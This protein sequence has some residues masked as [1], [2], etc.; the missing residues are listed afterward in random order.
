M[1]RSAAAQ[2]S[3]FRPQRIAR[4]LVL[5]QS[6]S[7]SRRPQAA[8]NASAL[9]TASKT[10]HSGSSKSS[11]HCGD[12]LTAST[13]ERASNK[14]R[15]RTQAEHK[16]QIAATAALQGKQFSCRPLLMIC[17]KKLRQHNQLV[18]QLPPLV[19]QR[20]LMRSNCSKGFAAARAITY[21][22][23]LGCCC[24]PARQ[25]LICPISARLRRK[26]Q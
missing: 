5:T 15:R 16:Q 10:E 13:Y 24:L 2:V 26:L 1:K 9:A 11:S 6:C 21:Y 12:L 4:G 18:R 14:N 8:P 17:R 25:P 23:H 7:L 22:S 20:Q 19:R 3:F